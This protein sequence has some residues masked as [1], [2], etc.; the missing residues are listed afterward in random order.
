MSV[1]IAVQDYV[2]APDLDADLAELT[3]A[4]V[5]GWPDQRPYTAAFLRSRLRPRCMTATT[6]VLGRE[7]GGRLVAAAALRWPATLEDSGHLFGPIVHPDVRGAGVGTDMLAAMVDVIA[8]RPG[9][10]VTTIAVPESRTIGWALFERAGWT[11]VRTST[12]LQRD[13]PAD[14]LLTTVPV[15]AARPGE[16]LDPAIAALV[17]ARR[18]VSYAGARDTLAQW[19][20]DERYTSDGLLLVD[21]PDGLIGA[22]LVYPLANPGICEPAEARLE[23]ILIAERLDP[24]TATQVRAAL[25]AAALHVGAAAGASVAR[26][27]VNDADLVATLH[28]AGFEVV[29]Q[30]RYYSPPPTEPALAGTA[31]G[32]TAA[33]VAI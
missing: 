32:A 8:N 16:Y 25:V 28:G 22:A 33:T 2:P 5:H 23:E 26:A 6:L 4:A 9:L 3:Y 27:E 10:R 19:R 31:A 7:P 18:E 24:E 14:I 30:I 1:D 13:L 17:A 20:A 11:L 21:G 12:L 15:R 29:D